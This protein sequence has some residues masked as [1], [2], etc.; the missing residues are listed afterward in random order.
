[1]QYVLLTISSGSKDL[2]FWTMFQPSHLTI[3]LG[4]LKKLLRKPNVP[5]Q[6]LIQRLHT[7]ETVHVNRSKTVGLARLHD[8]GLV[9]AD[10][11]V[12]GQ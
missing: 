2:V 10:V 5:I 1:V 8:K 12:V 9:T 11:C 3:F 6:Q 7:L 4:K